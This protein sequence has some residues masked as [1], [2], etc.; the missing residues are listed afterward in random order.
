MSLPQ[1]DLPYR[2]PE[3]LGTDHLGTIGRTGNDPLLVTRD[4]TMY[5]WTCYQEKPMNLTINRLQITSWPHTGGAR[6][7]AKLGSM[8]I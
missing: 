4:A 2:L 8:G 1:T 7:G 3:D 6:N 5:Q